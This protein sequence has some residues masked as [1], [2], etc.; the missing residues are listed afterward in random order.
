MQ[1][2]RQIFGPL[3]VTDAERFRVGSDEDPTCIEDEKKGVA[4]AFVS[5]APRQTLDGEQRCA[6]IARPLEDL[7]TLHGPC[8]SC[9]HHSV[10][11]A[12]RNTRAALPGKNRSPTRS[13][14]SQAPAA[15][16]TLL[17]MY[18]DDTAVPPDGLA[19]RRRR[20]ERG[21]SPR[22][23]IDELEQR[24]F[25]ATGL[26]ATITPNLLAG[27]EERGE[28]IPYETLC[29]L[30]DALDCDPID[31]VSKPSDEED[32]SGGD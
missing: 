9:C 17:P 16:S 14:S 32:E 28:T 24:H 3:D 10:C 5:V 12:A 11:E 20:H 18:D 15:E 4:Q 29:M 21:W 23:L 6:G 30:S 19:V 31:L 22:R 13:G 1:A 26:R 8:L 25:A 27:I 7:E 2:H